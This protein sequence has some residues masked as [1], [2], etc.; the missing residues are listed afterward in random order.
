MQRCPLAGSECGL[1]VRAKPW[2]AREVARQSLVGHSPV[3]VCGWM[4]GAPASDPVPLSGRPEPFSSRC[5]LLRA[6]LASAT[7]AENVSLIYL[8]RCLK[9]MKSPRSSPSMSLLFP[10]LH[11]SLL[12]HVSFSVFVRFAPFLAPIYPPLLLTC[13]TAEENEQRKRDERDRSVGG[14]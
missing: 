13:L 11:F 7:L 4:G 8:F 10:T 14:G 3:C 2:E 1:M 9:I 12:L 5:F 6:G